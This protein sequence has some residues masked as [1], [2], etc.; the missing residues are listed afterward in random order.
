MTTG[1]DKEKNGL[2]RP[3]WEQITSK[4]EHGR[5]MQKTSPESYREWLGA[6]R[7]MHKGEHLGQVEPWSPYSVRETYYPGW[8]D[9]DFGTLL[10]QLGE[11]HP[12]KD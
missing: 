5:N 11:A 3:N 4:A 12:L 1:A 9:G 2:K 10:N 7:R 6:V 8:A